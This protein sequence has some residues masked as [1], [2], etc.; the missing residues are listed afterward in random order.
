[1]NSSTE[2]DPA[3]FPRKLNLG[4]GWDRREGYLNVDLNAFYHPDLV[5]DIRNL[6]MLP[7][8]HYVE[9]VAQDVLE[10]L[11]RTATA[12]TLREWNRLL[13]IGGLLRLRIPS[14]EGLTTLFAKNPT[15]AKQCELMQCLF[16]TQ[17]YTGDFHLT[18]FSKVLL[19]GYLNRTGFKLDQLSMRDGWLF[20]ATAR[21]V[22]N[23]G[24]SL[25]VQKTK[26]LKVPSDEVFL[27][28][29]YEVMLHRQPD[30][31]GRAFYGNALAAGQLK[32]E[33]VLASIEGSPEFRALHADTGDI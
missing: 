13:E 4:C 28:K 7:P 10:H 14:I 22:A 9:I 6:P 15:F 23:C 19:E 3:Q 29:V 2:I 26:L 12:S 16:G 5:C 17:A 1:M 30:S 33:E 25:D 24:P 18:S 11:P 32:R 27:Q 21:K 31:E 8:S 20:D